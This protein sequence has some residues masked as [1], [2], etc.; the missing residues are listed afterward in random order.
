MGG[1]SNSNLPKLMKNPDFCDFSKNC[2]IGFNQN[3][4]LGDSVLS[5]LLGFLC[6]NKPHRAMR[7]SQLSLWAF[8]CNGY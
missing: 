5:I 3:L 4:S 2:K 1:S 7:R 6:I 8:F